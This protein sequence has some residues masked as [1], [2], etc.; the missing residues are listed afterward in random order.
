MQNYRGKNI[1][2]GKFGGYFCKI[3]GTKTELKYTTGTF[4][5]KILCLGI[6]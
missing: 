5:Q 6:F 4:L 2:L 3:I 1:I